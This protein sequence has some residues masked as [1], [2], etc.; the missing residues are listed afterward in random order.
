MT[1]ITVTAIKRASNI[2]IN[3]P[4]GGDGTV[5]GT[6]Q[7]VLNS[8]ETY[9]TETVASEVQIFRA[10]S[11]ATPEVQAAVQTLIDAVLVWD[12]EDNPQT[13]V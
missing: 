1:D 4:T 12:Q 13:R 2:Q 8:P 9:V 11:A 5:Q 10:L 3:L 6:V 7:I